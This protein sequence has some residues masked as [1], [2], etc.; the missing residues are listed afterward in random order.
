LG[1][2][3]LQLLRS[4][5]YDAATIAMLC[6]DGVVATPAGPELTS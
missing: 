1:E 6:A 5:G 4:L 3:S 2:H